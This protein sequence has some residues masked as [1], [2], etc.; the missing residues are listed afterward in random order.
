MRGDCP[1]D[2]TDARRAALIEDWARRKVLPQTLRFQATA[3]PAWHV[4]TCAPV[5]C[6]ASRR[7]V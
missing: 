1:L 4:R 6:V 7:I 3:I 5:C 2:I